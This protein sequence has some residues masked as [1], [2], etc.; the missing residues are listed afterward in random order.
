VLRFVPPLVIT[1]DEIDD[2]IDILKQ[3]LA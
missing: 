2:A 3:V 1:K